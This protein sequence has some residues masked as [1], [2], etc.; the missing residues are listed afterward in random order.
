MNDL[1]YIVAHLSVSE[2][3]EESG[4]GGAASSYGAMWSRPEKGGDV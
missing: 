4:Q 1:D 3:A 2:R